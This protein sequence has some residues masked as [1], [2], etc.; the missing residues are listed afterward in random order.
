MF[1][2]IYVYVS[3]KRKVDKESLISEI[4]IKSRKIAEQNKELR[5]QENRAQRDNFLAALDKIHKKL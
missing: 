4:I 5:H 2:F 3:R 1:M